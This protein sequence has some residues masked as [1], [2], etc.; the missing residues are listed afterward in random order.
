MK[1]RLWA[2]EKIEKGYRNISNCLSIGTK[3]DKSSHDLKEIAIEKGWWNGIDAFHW[4][5]I[6]GGQSS[7]Q[8]KSPDHRWTCGKELLEK[9][10]K[11]GKFSV[12]D[13]MT[14]LRDEASGINRPSGDFPTA[15]SQVSTLSDAAMK[16]VHWFTASLSPSRYT[17]I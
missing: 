5:S 12:V 17:K 14:V 16:S 1:F 15:A 13:M 8:L 3:F 2:A 7:G 10:S 6:L 9:G 4:S 11:D